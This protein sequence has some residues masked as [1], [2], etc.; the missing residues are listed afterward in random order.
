MLRTYLR[1]AIRNIRSYKF[2]SAI[3][4][5]G[6]AI[7]LMVCMLIVLYTKDEISFDRFHARQANIFRIGQ[8]MQLGK[9]Q[10]F[11]IGITQK[12]LGPAFKKEIPEIEQ[13]V[14]HNQ[15]QATIRKGAEI[16][17][18]NPLFVDSN[19]FSMFSFPIL[20]GNRRN[21]LDDM[22]SIVFQDAVR[23]YFPSSEP[24]GQ[25]PGTQDE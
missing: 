16:Y 21:P 23:K 2:F 24:I 19:F 15:M 6:L 1:V 10:P 5:G 9:D 17:I 4:I 14:R 25:T 7:G 3:K 12:P 8:T 22:H 11:K 18:E 20:R 13:Y